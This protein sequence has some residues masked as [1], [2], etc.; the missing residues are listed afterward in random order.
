MIES[1]ID[2]IADNIKLSATINGVA[3]PLQDCIEV[4]GRFCKPLMFLNDDHDSPVSIFGSSLLFRHDSRNIILFTKHQLDNSGRSAGE[5]SLMLDAPKFPGDPSGIIAFLPDSAVVVPKQPDAENF[6]DI[7]FAEFPEKCN[8]YDFTPN[9][10]NL[11]LRETADLN[12]VDKDKIIAIFAVGYPTESVSYDPGYDE[13]G[14]SIG[15]DIVFGR[16]SLYLERAEHS[17]FDKDS[18]I[19]LRISKE[20]RTSIRNPDGLSGAPVF[21]TYLDDRERAHI[22]LVGIITDASN[23]G[24]FSIYSAGIIKQVIVRCSKTIC[25]DRLQGSEWHYERT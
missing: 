4:L 2:I 8:G 20:S 5:V 1:L 23:D 15:P 18:R 22:G 3:V 16:H 24:L 19:H 11:D 9:F 14:E 21:F 6:R 7:V 17:A 12:M 25:V 13:D 10:I